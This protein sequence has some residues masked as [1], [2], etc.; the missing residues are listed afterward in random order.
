MLTVRGERLKRKGIAVDIP[1][2][3]GHP[4]PTPRKRFKVEDSSIS[5]VAAPHGSSS[6]LTVSPQSPVSGRSKKPGVSLAGS[7]SPQSRT[8]TPTSSSQIPV[9][10]PSGPPPSKD[11]TV[12][13]HPV[14]A[15]SKSPVDLSSTKGPHVLNH[16]PSHSQT[17]PAGTPPKRSTID[18]PGQA[19]SANT[20]PSRPTPSQP[21]RANNSPEGSSRHAP[22]QTGP[23][24]AGRLSQLDA[25]QKLPRL[26]TKPAPKRSDPQSVSS[27][28]S[29]SPGSHGRSA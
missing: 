4:R 23:S 2:L 11:P 9:R 24:T 6:C 18:A 25:F 1:Q 21:K 14:K 29:Q 22:S 28:S 10:A 15:L 8:P 27:S 12:L 3:P 7:S 26:Q 17:K 19:K 13:P 5:K 20:S 16:G